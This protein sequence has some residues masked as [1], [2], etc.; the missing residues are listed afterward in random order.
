MIIALNFIL[1]IKSKNLNIDEIN[2][3]DEE[4]TLDRNEENAEKKQEDK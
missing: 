2:D 4:Y 3:V 1:N